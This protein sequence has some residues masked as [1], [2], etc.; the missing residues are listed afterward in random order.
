MIKLMLNK[1]NNIK[2][3]FAQQII[4]FLVILFISSAYF[5]SIPLDA[6]FSN[7]AKSCCS[8]L[9]END[10]AINEYAGN[11]CSC[12][13]GVCRCA[14]KDKLPA[15][16]P[17]NGV[18]KVHAAPDFPVYGDNYFAVFNIFALIF[19]DPPPEIITGDFISK[20][21]IYRLKS[22]MLC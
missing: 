13:S 2:I 3:K 4:S 7:S 6:A 8:I 11:G 12:C 15:D 21:P 1:K 14:F 18:L 10:S 19:K 17:L 16:I 5:S 20:I 9:D 22:S